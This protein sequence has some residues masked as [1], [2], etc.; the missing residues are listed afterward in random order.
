[1]NQLIESLMLVQKY[2]DT[3]SDKIFKH[4]FRVFSEIVFGLSF[5]NYWSNVAWLVIVLQTDLVKF[6]ISHLSCRATRQRLTPVLHRDR[7][8]KPPTQ[9]IVSPSIVPPCAVMGFPFFE[10]CG[11]SRYIFPCSLAHCWSSIVQCTVRDRFAS[12]NPSQTIQ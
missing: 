9:R 3:L 8:V 12:T 5:S 10:W 2:L 11:N 7:M 4:I 1:M 6:S